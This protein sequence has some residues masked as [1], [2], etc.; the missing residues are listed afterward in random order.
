M[1]SGLMLMIQFLSLGIN[2]QCLDISL[3]TQADI[4]N[5][6]ANYG[7]SLIE[8]NLTISGADINNL[9]GLSSLS[10]IQGSLTIL[11]C[12]L[13][14]DL[15]G[16]YN[17]NT[18][19]NITINQCASLTSINGFNNITNLNGFALFLCENLTSVS[20][21]NSLESIDFN[22][23]FVGIT[24]LEE[25]SGFNAL[26]Y[27]GGRFE[28][29]SYSVPV[30]LTG[31]T[32]FTCAPFSM[33]LGLVSDISGLA[34]LTVAYNFEA[35]FVDVPDFT[36][37]SN[38]ETGS[39][40]IGY[41]NATATDL[42]SLAPLT[43]LGDNVS[44]SLGINGCDALTSLVGLEGFTTLNTLDVINNAN[45]SS[46]NGIQNI[47]SITN[48]KIED[49][50]NLTALANLSNLNSIDGYFIVS[51]TGLTNL[52]GLSNVEY[53]GGYIHILDNPNITNFNFGGLIEI[54]GELKISG[55]HS[56][57][58]LQI[59]SLS[60]VGVFNVDNNDG[61]ISMSGL[62]S[63]TEIGGTTIIN[64]DNLAACIYINDIVN[65]TLGAAVVENNGGCG[66]ILNNE[67]CGNVILNG[68]AAVDAFV[69]N[70]CNYVEGL[71]I[72]GAD[73]VDLSGLSTINRV[74]SSGLTVVFCTALTS[75]SGLD[76][77]TQVDGQI[78][79]DL[80][81][82]LEDLTGLSNLQTVGGRLNVNNCSL[83]QDLTGLGS[84]TKLNYLNIIS[85]SGLKSLNGLD[86]LTEVEI[87]HVSLSDS[88]LSLQ[89]MPLVTEISDNVSIYA[90][91]SL[92]DL[93]GFENVT[94]VGKLNITSNIALTSLNGLDNLTSVNGDLT[95]FQNDT[96]T[97]ISSL[98]NISSVGL[99]E[100]K[101]ND[102][103]SEC[104][105]IPDL[106]GV[107]YLN[108]AII[109]SNATNCNSLVEIQ[110]VSCPP[111]AWGSVIATNQSG[112]FRGQVQVE[113][114]PAEAGDWLAAFDSNGNIVG[115][116]S[117][118][119]NSGIAYINMVI[120]GD[121]PT[122]T[123]IDEGMNAGEYFTI[124]LY[125]S[126]ENAYYDYTVNGQVFEFT[127]WESTNGVPMAAYSNSNDIYNFLLVQLCEQT[128]NLNQGWNLISLD[129][130]PSD[131]SIPVVF[132][133]LQSGNLEYVTGFEGGTITYNPNDPPF[134]NTLSNVVDGSAYWV[135]VQSSDV[136]IVSGTCLDDTFRKQL[137]NGWNLVAFI[138]DASEA[139]TSYFSDLISN[140][141]LEYVTGFNNG[142]LTFNP[143]DPPFLNTLQ[144]MENGL[145]YWL[146]VVNQ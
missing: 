6:T 1:L 12:P 87:L 96:L 9:D 76:N 18:V 136:L 77:I 23:D 121:D 54:A 117:L 141:D 15:S 40:S 120:Y 115:I 97:D 88:L 10:D 131:S 5:F 45:L 32:S 84:L 89:G 111:T 82:A 113:G 25:I 65:V 35:S 106:V 94:Q 47:S 36:P 24:S 58:D 50:T 101:D 60:K 29:Q 59:F 108:K 79:L 49:C 91:F 125:D 78:S 140:G 14:S 71:R 105:I 133:S 2:A 72:S 129:L 143:N 139:P 134:L 52:N 48:L 135:R 104:C 102:L 63:L 146:K 55:N 21:F 74:G 70:G 99:V 28:I 19:E 109:R 83:L 116:D 103:L 41:S 43:Q 22:F 142:T 130:S 3:S 138:P 27:V 16:I 118:T 4:D 26:E 57:S 107:S 144:Q 44:I 90:N 8:G 46:L 17:L 122:T 124:Q 98:R 33:R 68:Q 11:Q 66:T 123:G 128:I 137:N 145:G 127:Q 42:F 114:I 119:I 38:V 31:F 110:S 100:I 13:L 85:N 81:Y 62:S 132:S 34:N 86:N 112:I 80:L 69:S 30:A 39:L 126:S 95:V 53:V 73:V 75:L 20:G 64:N 56:I 61:L 7:C 37:L 67:N 51:N 92:P 93:S